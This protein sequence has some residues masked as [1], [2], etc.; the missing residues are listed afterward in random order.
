MNDDDGIKQIVDEIEYLRAKRAQMANVTPRLVVV[1]GYHQAVKDC[2]PGETIE[3]VSIAVRSDLFQLRLSPKGLVI[4]D[5][6]AQKKP[7]ALTAAHIEQILAS[8]PFYL[9]LGA[10]AASSPRPTTRLTRKTIKVYIHRLRL[11][12]GKALKKAGLAIPPEKVLV[13]ES[14]DLL[15]VTAYRLAIPCEF[16]H[17][18]VQAGHLFDVK[19]S[20]RQGS[21]ADPSSLSRRNLH[22]PQES[23][24][25]S[26]IDSRRPSV[27]LPR[28]E[29][30]Q[31]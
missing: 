5:I 24:S 26:H 17:M 12:I 16:V 25:A 29:A 13:S 3:R 21:H 23:A 11:Q 14:T 4:A 31:L 10:N 27:G 1:H 15:N 20:S 19:N 22:D 6:I 30:G 7:I 18:G 9:R 2:L 8:D 28:L